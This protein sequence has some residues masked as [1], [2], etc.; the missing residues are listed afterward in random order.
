VRVGAR[1]RG[2]VEAGRG[3]AAQDDVRD[4]LRGPHD[5]RPH[6]GGQGQ[7]RRRDGLLTP[8][9]NALDGAAV[10]G[11]VI[12]RETAARQVNDARAR[13]SYGEFARL[14]TSSARLPWTAAAA[15]V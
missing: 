2:D 3:I 6:S 10:G 8:V 11:R 7:G 14:A 15:T 9:V 1:E 5:G 4:R 13:T 12:E